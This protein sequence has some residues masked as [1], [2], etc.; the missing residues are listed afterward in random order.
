MFNSESSV[1]A[2]ATRVTAR[3]FEYDSRPSPK[4]SEIF[5]SDVNARATR[6]FSLAA[7]A[8]MPHCQ[9]SQWAQLATPC[10]AQ[11]SLRSNSARRARNCAVAALMCPE[12]YHE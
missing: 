6:T 10:C 5:G 4:A 2:V 8:L 1:S 11:P 3:T 9:F 7:P 12:L